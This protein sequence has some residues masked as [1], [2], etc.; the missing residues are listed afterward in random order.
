[1]GSLGKASTNTAQ[2][3][4]CAVYC[5]TVLYYC[6][7]LLAVVYYPSAVCVSEFYIRERVLYV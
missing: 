3:P 6:I 1:M 4:Y 2:H 7:V 5:T